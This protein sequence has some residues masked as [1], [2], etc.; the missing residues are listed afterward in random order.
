MKAFVEPI[1][2]VEHWMGDRPV[3]ES[4]RDA[5]PA[6]GALVGTISEIYH[7]HFYFVWRNARRLGVPEANLDDVA[8]DVFIV[9]D[10]RLPDFDGRVQ[11]RAWIFGILVRVVR[12]Y[13]RTFLRK[14]A[15]C[16]PLSH[17]AMVS[18]AP[19]PSDVAER[20][21]RMEVLEMLLRE[22]DE[23]KAMLIVLSELEQWTLREIAEYMG[24]NTN[25]IY[26]RLTVAK[27]DF[28]RAY[29]RWLAKTGEQRE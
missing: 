3:R 21:E 9:V 1:G 18:T 6:N 4:S 19:A 24:S 29:A 23:N 28:D 8:Q 15:R 5:K 2:P 25:T 14:Q 17:E 7:E 22:L 16:V 12:K 13:R 11:L 27:R 20:T 10:R 26:S